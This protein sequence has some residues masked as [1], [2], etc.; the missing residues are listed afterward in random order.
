MLRRLVEAV[1]ERVVDELP[2]LLVELRV[3]LRGRVGLRTQQRTGLRRA[4]DREMDA[5]VAQWPE[6]LVLEVVERDGLAV[7]RPFLAT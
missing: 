2:R 7:Q 3:E 5:R 6:D 1:A 4:D